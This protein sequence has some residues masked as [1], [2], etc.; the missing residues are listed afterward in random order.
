MEK[1]VFNPKQF[2]ETIILL[3]QYGTAQRGKDIKAAQIKNKA[4]QVFGGE[5]SRKFPDMT[6][7]SNSSDVG[8]VVVSLLSTIPG[9]STKGI[10]EEASKPNSIALSDQA[11]RVDLRKEKNNSVQ[12]Y[13][14]F[15]SAFPIPDEEYFTLQFDREDDKTCM[16]VK[17][18]MDS[19]CFP[20]SGEISI[21]E[22]IR[23]G[24]IPRHSVKFG[25]DSVVTKGSDNMNLIKGEGL[26][27]V[28]L[29]AEITSPDNLDSPVNINQIIQKA[30]IKQLPSITR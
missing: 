20:R 11:I 1:Q 13:L 8:K 23:S 7:I 14:T 28:K 10:I 18:R 30:K 26:D 9:V 6:P 29:I 4:F 2:E 16:S 25:Q 19:E 17:I 22:V 5:I 15:P 3:K 27:I 24:R 12:M 21:S